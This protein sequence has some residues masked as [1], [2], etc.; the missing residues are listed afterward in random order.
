M[1]SESNSGAQ[2]SEPQAGSARVP[3][4][5]LALVAMLAFWGMGFLHRHAA[6]FQPK[7]YAPYKSRAELDMDQPRLRGDS[8]FL[9]GKKV[10]EETARCI[11]CH[12]ANGQGV[13]NQFPPLAGSEW[14]LAKEPGRLIRIVLHGLHGPVTVKDEAFDS[15]SMIPWKDQLS[16]EELAVVLTFIRSNKEWHNEAPPV[17]AEQVKAVRDKTSGRSAPWFIDELLKVHESE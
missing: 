16:D 11:L 17:S 14:V 3:A 12:Q 7:V 13:A 8:V 5:L 6:G 15:P 10:Y 9:Q 1:S 2:E 4:W